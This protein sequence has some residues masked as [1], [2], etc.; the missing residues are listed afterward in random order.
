MA[1]GKVVVVADIKVEAVVRAHQDQNLMTCALGVMGAG[2]GGGNV[3]IS[4]L[5]RVWVTL[6]ALAPVHN[7]SSRNNRL[8]SISD[9]CVNSQR[10]SI[11]MNRC[12]KH[13]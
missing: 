4:P 9:R 5:Y 13:Q 1:E 3:P 10:Y 6:N 11:S 7:N 8:N 12:P 2:I